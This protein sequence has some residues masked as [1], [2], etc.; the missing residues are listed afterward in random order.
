M[1]AL[2]PRGP[3]HRIRVSSECVNPLVPATSFCEPTYLPGRDGK[4]VLTWF[5]L[6]D[7]RPL[8]AFAG[9]W[10]TL[11]RGPR[12]AKEPVEGEHMLMAS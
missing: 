2:M 3:S 4:K 9:I 8:F 12:D 1:P 11:A 10:C 6:G 7:D 5:G